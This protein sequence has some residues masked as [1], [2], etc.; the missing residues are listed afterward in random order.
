MPLCRNCH[1][2]IDDRRLELLAH[3][4][5]EFRSELGHALTHVSL[6][7]LVSRV[8]AGRWLV[9]GPRDGKERREVA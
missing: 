8:P 2:V 7:W 9:T 6:A 5:P 3:L 1:R 4:E